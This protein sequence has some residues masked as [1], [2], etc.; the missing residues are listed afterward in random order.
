MK[1]TTIMWAGKQLD[2]RE[3]A[4]LRRVIHTL[5][6]A[7]ND[8]LADDLERFLPQREFG[9]TADEREIGSMVAREL[10]L[11]ACMDGD[12]GIIIDSA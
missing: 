9:W 8:E 12:Q 7:R 4:T 11:R 2:R 3:E 5:R 6:R 1:S 10:S